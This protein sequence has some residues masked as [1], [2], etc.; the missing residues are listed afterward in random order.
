[1]KGQSRERRRTLGSARAL[2][3][4]AAARAARLAGRALAAG[5]ARARRVPP[6]HAALGAVVRQQVVQALLKLLRRV[7][8]LI[9]AMATARVPQC[10]H[11]S[12]QR[13][14]PY[15][16][17]AV[18][19]TRHEVGGVDTGQLFG[20]HSLVAR[21]H[22][23]GDMTSVAPSRVNDR[24]R[25]ATAARLH[26]LLK[27]RARDV[28]EPDQVLAELG[29]GRDGRLALRKRVRL[30][31]RQPVQLLQVQLGVA[32]PTCGPEARLPKAAFNRLLPV[33]HQG[34]C[35][36]ICHTLHGLATD[37]LDFSQSAKTQLHSYP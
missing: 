9:T 15:T 21:P 17:F 3:C 34:A 36:Q 11:A 27:V 23:R 37:M 2:G 33:Y 35:V 1:M 30:L 14:L 10:T 12:G 24:A 20:V 28:G 8:M 5:G 32:L 25:G 19:S 26:E 6:L 4:S 7:C 29:P 18:A 22:E 13:P 31:L 16:G